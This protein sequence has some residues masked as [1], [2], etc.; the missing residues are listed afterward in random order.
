MKYSLIRL[1]RQSGAHCLPRMFSLTIVAALTAWP[2][3]ATQEDWPESGGRHYLEPGSSAVD[4][5][6]SPF[7]TAIESTVLPSAEPLAV[8]PIAPAPGQ[9]NGALSGRIIFAGARHGWVYDPNYWRLCR[10]VYAGINED[11]GNLDQMTMFA[12]YCFNAGATVVPLRP[13]G[14]QTNEVVLDNVVVAP[15]PLFSQTESPT[16]RASA[17]SRMRRSQQERGHVWRGHDW[18]PLWTRSRLSCP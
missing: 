2:A 7:E 16:E 14:H 15:S 12:Y 4:A 9:P 18:H 10:P 3:V 8:G 1:G 6:A 13:V 11:N 17:R 5:L